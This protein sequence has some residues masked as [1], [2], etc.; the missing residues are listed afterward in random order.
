MTRRRRPTKSQQIAI[1]DRQFGRCAICLIV[2]LNPEWDHIQAL[3][4]GGNNSTE[5]FQ[6]LCKSCHEIKTHGSKATSAGS[7]IHKIAKAR[8]IAR[9]GKTRKGPRLR[10]RGF[11]KRYRK[12]MDGRAEERK[13]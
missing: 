6:A 10:S 13:P 8:R 12:R 11:E 4:L 3:E 1:L 5:N 9:G 2:P 7:D